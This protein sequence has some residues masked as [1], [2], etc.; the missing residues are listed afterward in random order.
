MKKWIATVLAL[1]LALG[2]CSVSWAAENWTGSGTEADP[3]VITTAEQLAVLA[4]AV[5]SGTAY[6]GTYFKLGNDITVADWTPIGQ[7]KN[8]NNKFAGS[9]DGNGRTVTI[10]GISNS[11]DS[12]F[13][14]YAALF[15]A[16]KGA[17]IK[18]VTVTGTISGADVA[19]V[20]GQMNGGTVENCVNKATVTGTKKAAGIVV[21][22]KNSGSAVIKDCVNYGEIKSTGDRAGGIV[23]LVQIATEVLNC[24]NYGAVTSEATST[25]AAGGIVG[26]VGLEQSGAQFKIDGCE[27]TA[28]VS[29]KGAAGGILGGAS[30]SVGTVSSCINSGTVT[31]SGT[32]GTSNEHANIGGVVGQGHTDMEG[33]T[34]T[35]NTST[36]ALAGSYTRRTIAEDVTLADQSYSQMVICKGAKVEI[37]AGKI[38]N[39][40]TNYG[41]LAIIKG[42][43]IGESGEGGVNAQ[44]QNYGTA[45]LNCVMKAGSIHSQQGA[46]TV[47]NGGEYHFTCTEEMR[48]GLQFVAGKFIDLRSG[49]GDV[50][51][52]DNTFRSYVAEGAAVVYDAT[53]KTWTVSMP[54]TGVALNKSA[55][56]LQVGK[57]ETLTATVT[58]E[59]ASEPVVTWTSSDTTV[60][61]VNEN[62]VVTAVAKGT[63]TI[64]ATAGGKSAVCTVTVTAASGGYYYYYPSTDTT[65]DTAKASPKTF[66]AGMGIYAVTTV[67]SVTGMAW[68][69]KKRH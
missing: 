22:T 17:T 38:E 51:W 34:A 55:M 3:Y 31:L 37:T 44:I 45:T 43:Q 30:G 27:N 56:E 59:N 41:T 12:A 19:G 54:V 2:L 57:T 7:K 64:T 60:A 11:L 49:S 68:V 32:A 29:G 28:A 13:G 58:P 24:K 46:A 26:W 66:D 61:T 6:S 14:G 33:L 39:Y 1:V 40:L 52:G 65:T 42:A 9:F 15:G 10:N 36:G 53:A 48:N 62:G 67:L 20:V 63:A 50:Q 69:G 8:D 47:F 35:G 16:I 23:N 4:T 18:N 5:N 21:Y 25:Y